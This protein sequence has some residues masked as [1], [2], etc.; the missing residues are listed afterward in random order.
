MIKILNTTNS[1]KSITDILDRGENVYF[2]RYGDNDIMMM[3]GTRLD[4]SPLGSEQAFGGNK[5]IFSI[6]LQRE[7]IEAFQ[8]NN[9]NYLIGVSCTWEK[10]IGMDKGCFEPFPYKNQLEQKINLFTNKE[11]FLIPILFHY[12]ICF[13]PQI[14]DL[15]VEKYIKTRNVLFVGSSDKEHV[16]KLIGHINH[17]VET[18]KTTAYN[19][20]ENIWSEILI[21]L[22]NN[23]GINMIIPTSGQ[24]SRVLTKRLWNYKGLNISVIDMGSLFDGLS[25]TPTRTW[26]KLKGHLLRERYNSLP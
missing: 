25:T 8:I 2:S 5:T 14:F 7:L 22:K 4:N 9:P 11:E 1:L 20:I 24:C 15:F 3:S 23:P 21:V 19:Q 13:K 26:I 10:E 12:L 17:Y 6:E 16:E 18:P